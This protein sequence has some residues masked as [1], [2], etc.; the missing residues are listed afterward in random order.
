MLHVLGG[1]MLQKQRKNITITVQFRSIRHPYVTVTR[2]TKFLFR[3]FG[4]RVLTTAKFRQIG[5]S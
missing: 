3:H 5:P 4:W 1:E 2:L